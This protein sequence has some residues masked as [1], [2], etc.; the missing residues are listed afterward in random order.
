[1]AHS[2]NNQNEINIRISG[3]SNGLYEYHFSAEPSAIGLDANFYQAV[4]VNA[5]LEKTSHQIYI[6]TEI[7]TPGRFRCDR[8]LDEFE[9]S[10]KANFNMCY[11]YNALETGKFPSEEIQAISPDTVSID[12]T[13]DIR[14]MIML[15]VPL[16]LLCAEN[17]MGLCTHCGTNKNHE[18]CN[19]K[20]EVSDPRWQGLHELLKH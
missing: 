9:I 19:C 11:M 3:L 5:Q 4:E 7:E 2:K 12:L 20:E 17:C 8:C 1:M 13:E 18:L 16:K 10:I 6:K 14:Q 15:S